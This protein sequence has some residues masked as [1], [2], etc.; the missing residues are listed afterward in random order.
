MTESRIPVTPYKGLIPY[1]EEDAPF[2]FGRDPEREIIT[3]NLMASRLTLLYGA[4]GVG[5]S[6]VL[7]A[8]VEHHLRK[9]ARQNMAKRGKPEFA[10][11]VFNRWRDNPRAYLELEVLKSVAAAFNGSPPEAKQMPDDFVEMLRVNANRVGGRLLIILDQFEEY[12]LYH[13]QENGPGTF[14]TDFPRAIN[15][16]G[17]RVDFLISIREDAL[18]KLDRFEASIPN[19]FDNYLRIEHLDREAARDAIV[20]PVE[21]YN[22]RRAAARPVSIEPALIE[23][24]LD[25]VKTGQVVIGEAGRGSVIREDDEAKIETPFLQ[26][27]MTRLWQEEMRN[28]SHVLRLETLK[29]LGGAEPIVKTHLDEAMNEMDAEDR[30]VAARIFRYLVTPSGTK[31]AYS[32]ADLADYGGLRT[33][34]LDSL[35]EKLSASDARILRPVAPP[36]DQP[37]VLRYEIFHDVLAPAILDWRTRYTEVQKQ[38]ETQRQLELEAQERA[39][40]EERLAREQRLVLRQRW[41]LAAMG[42]LLVVMAGLTWLAFELRAEAKDAQVREAEQRTLAVVQRNEAEKA[43]TDAFAARDETRQALDRE[44]NQRKE[45]EDQRNAAEKAKAEANRQ[46]LAA[47]AAK[48]EAEEQRDI[49]QIALGA[50][51]TAA[52]DAGRQKNI[53]VQARR[54]AERQKDIAE[55]AR[56]DAEQARKN[57]EQREGE[58]KSA[59][60]DA[61]A[62]RARA[63][64]MLNEVKKQD[65]NAKHVVA[66]LREDL[67]TKEIEKAELYGKDEDHLVIRKKDGSNIVWKLEG[68]PGSHSL[69][70]AKGTSLHEL[71]QATPNIP[72]DQQYL[73]VVKNCQPP[74]PVFQVA[75]P[76]RKESI[77]L[78]CDQDDPAL[79]VLGPNQKLVAT[80]DNDGIA[81]V[82]DVD[83]NGQKVAVLRPRS[84]LL[85]Y[86][87][88]K[89]PFLSYDYLSRGNLAG[90]NS[91]A[92]D[93][94]S[95]YLVTAGKDKTVRVYRVKSR[96]PVAIFIGHTDEVLKA[97]F[98]PSGNKIISVG[99]DQ[100]VRIWDFTKQ[101]QSQNCKDCWY[102]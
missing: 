88:K 16:P 25:Q 95:E 80:A 11:I 66:T 7:R 29:R 77:A 33:A 83:K 89:F 97:A 47:E 12:F 74:N 78:R 86:S 72:N 22:H 43:R 63:E 39:K 23:A 91:V 79:V 76:G 84:A 48:V 2:F 45:A 8:G 98:S 68:N 71:R 28:G 53:A 55:L 42:V 69:V 34:Q 94:K 13:S 35:L 99:K 46:R 32:A 50:A 15:D 3:A 65:D 5:K 102:R 41:L 52:L 24:V 73:P 49:A 81:R 96:E 67:E 14:A 6:S 20:K 44:T 75:I 18:A 64:K 54:D 90:L 57:A 38:A 87:T 21:E 10:V 30:D 17:L 61:E 51:D 27:V 19:L 85:F 26:L 93:N 92:F 31:I 1:S 58:A 56:S 62:A 40:A 60:T 9:L 100:T 70:E 4:S 37:N 59:R 82:F 36:L 101:K